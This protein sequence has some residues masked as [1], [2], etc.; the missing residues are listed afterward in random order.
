MFVVE[1]EI[2]S[3]EE[4]WLIWHICHLDSFFDQ[5]NHFRIIFLSFVFPSIGMHS[6]FLD[7]KKMRWV[8]SWKW[9]KEKLESVRH[10]LAQH[11]YLE[12]ERATFSSPHFSILFKRD[13]E[14]FND[15]G[16]VRIWVRV[17]IKPEKKILIRSNL[18]PICPSNIRQENI[19]E[20]QFEA[21]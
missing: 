7:L 18:G 11:F 15:A 8:K 2:N 12:N 20:R 4:T 6:S 14:I 17:R 16:F 10:P 3:E 5:I 19:L 21:W 13:T 9:L 1:L